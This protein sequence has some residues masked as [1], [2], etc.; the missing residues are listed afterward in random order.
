MPYVYILECA[1]GTYYVGST[2]DLDLRLAQH[3]L[4][5]GAAYTRR[6]GRRPVT[7]RWHAEFE[8][9]DD[10]FLWEKQIQGW[11]HA[12]RTLLMEEGF[13]AVRG[14]SRR[15]RA[16]KR[17]DGAASDIEGEATG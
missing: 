14:W 5:Q 10:A 12:K 4:G 3:Q 2:R 17:A 15:Q 13:E 7:L 9:M 11:S 8:R 16:A 6:T 1:D